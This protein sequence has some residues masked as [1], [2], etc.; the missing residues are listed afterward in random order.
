M[1]RPPVRAGA[2][3]WPAKVTRRSVP[4]GTFEIS[5]TYA[6]VIDRTPVVTSWTSGLTVRPVRPGEI[7][8]FGELLAAH[9][10]L[11]TRLFGSVIRHAAILDGTW[12]A[13]LG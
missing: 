3:F 12:V 1:N 13:L 8:R 10:W 2:R 6:S 7:A 9:H 11:G 4:P 5:W